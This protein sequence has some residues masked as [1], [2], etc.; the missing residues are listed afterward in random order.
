[1]NKNTIQGQIIR[2]FSPAIGKYKLPDQTVN[3]INQHVDEILKDQNKIEELYNGDNLAGEIKY[4][5][6]IEKKFLDKYLYE[7]FKSYVFN[8]VKS[9]MSKEFKNFEIKSCWAVCQYENDYNPVH[10]H[11][12]NIS[13][14]TYTKVPKDFGTSYKKT[15]LNGNISF[16][17]GTTQLTAASNYNINPKVGDLY[18]FPSY[19]MHTVYP[20][21]STEERRSVSFNAF[22]DQE[23]VNL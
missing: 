17:H 16:I 9:A 4:E 21:F 22:L 2:P 5:V 7:I 11:T 6:K 12:G 18:I 15:N 19:L 13:A 1:M 14:V 8:Y 3:L 10:W 20:F 23:T